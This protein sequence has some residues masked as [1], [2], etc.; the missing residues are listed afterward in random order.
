MAVEA[1]AAAQTAGEPVA[2]QPA[3]QPDV[4]LVSVRAAAHTAVGQPVVPEH[5]LRTI[6]QDVV[7]AAAPPAVEPAVEP[8][9]GPAR[10]AAGEVGTPPETATPPARTAQLLGR[11]RALKRAAPR[12]RP[13]VPDEASTPRILHTAVRS[14]PDLPTARA[15]GGAAVYRRRLA[16][17]LA[18][19]RARLT[20]M[21]GDGG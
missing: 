15:A 8:A 17:Q 12:P 4:Q 6:T 13:A 1:Q 18:A 9:V 2:V 16:E 20:E 3:E 21:H 5:V 10:G 11:G 19:V 7:E 14:L